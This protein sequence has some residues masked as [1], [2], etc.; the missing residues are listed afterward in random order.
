MAAV[1][2]LPVTVRADE[3]EASR[4]RLYRAAR[5]RRH[6]ADALRADARSAGRERLHLPPTATID[7]LVDHL[8]A[9]PGSPDRPTLHALLTDGPVEDDRAL[10]RLAAD[11]AALT[12]PHPGTRPG[13]DRP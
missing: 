6:A 12:D 2:P 9:R 7:D 4:G 11:L 3:T 5:D 10:L 8:L 13:K 1:W